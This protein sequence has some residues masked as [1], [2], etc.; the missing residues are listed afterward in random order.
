MCDP[1]AL[2]SCGP[3]DGLGPGAFLDARQGLLYPLKL[4]NV[5]SLRSWFAWARSLSCDRKSRIAGAQSRGCA[6]T[7]AEDGVAVAGTEGGRLSVRSFCGGTER[8]QT[9][10]SE[11]QSCMGV[12]L[13]M[14]GW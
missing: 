7:D 5:E 3:F 12:N 8:G 14:W 13:R 1:F 10:S 11:R 9:Q 4:D 6:E 2:L